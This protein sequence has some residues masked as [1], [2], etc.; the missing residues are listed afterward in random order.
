MGV[1]SK[2]SREP[3]VCVYYFFRPV[4]ATPPANHTA[5][6]QYTPHYADGSDGTGGLGTMAAAYRK[7]FPRMKC[8]RK[9][10]VSGRT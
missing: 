10:A 6:R 9:E 8:Y 5:T 4:A 2:S 3:D 1:P 7:R